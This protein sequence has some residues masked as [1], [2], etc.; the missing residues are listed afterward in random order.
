[1]AATPMRMPSAE[2]AARSRRMRS[3][4]LAS[5]S[6]SPAARRDASRTRW[7]R[8]V[9]FDAAVHELDASIHG[10]GHHRAV[11]DDDYRRA[12]AMEVS[13]ELD[14]RDAGGAVE[15][16]GRLIREDDLGPAD[17]RAG[18]RGALALASGELGRSMHEAMTEADALQGNSGL[19]PALS[20]VDAAVEETG[21]DVVEH[22]HPIEEEELL[23]D[24]AEAGGAEA[25]ELTVAHAAGVDAVDA[26][27]A[28]G[29]PVER[30]RDVQQRSLPRSRRS[31]HGEQF[32]QLDPQAHLPKRFDRWIAGVAP[33]DVAQL[34]DGLAHG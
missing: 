3:P 9:A 25:G 33:H 15:I 13:Q 18:D 23:E 19:T 24:E 34:D 16:T 2:S 8:G 31:H 32:T 1:M 12:I 20:A 17:D 4:R 22:A 10:A 5:A 14:D 7:L 6:R 30:A 28:R 29:G 27:A 26:H 11:G 21:G